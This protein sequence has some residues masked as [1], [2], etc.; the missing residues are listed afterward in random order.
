VTA[1]QTLTRNGVRN[2]GI[3]KESD[4]RIRANADS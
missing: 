3:I 4:R 1:A 2:P